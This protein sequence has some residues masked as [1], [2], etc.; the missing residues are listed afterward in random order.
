MKKHW[1]IIKK[2]L[3]FEKQDLMYD[4]EIAA[5]NIEAELRGEIA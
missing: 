5:E 3:E 4:E 2:E 1:S